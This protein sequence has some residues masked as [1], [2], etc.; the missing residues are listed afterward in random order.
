MTPSLAL[1]VDV[2]NR[3]ARQDQGQ[4][5]YVPTLPAQPAQLQAGVGT[6]KGIVEAKPEA[7]KL[8]TEPEQP[9]PLL[10]WWATAE[11]AEPEPGSVAVGL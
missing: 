6:E 7:D 8:P 5:G 2:A 9:S 11:K 10:Q 3:A 1:R 4:T